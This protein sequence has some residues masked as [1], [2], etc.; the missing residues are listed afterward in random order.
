MLQTVK[1]EAK[2]LQMPMPNP[3]RIKKVQKSMAM[4]KVVIGER[5]RAVHRLAEIGYQSEEQGETTLEVDTKKLD[6]SS[7]GTEVMTSK[8]DP[9]GDCNEEKT[10]KV[11]E[12]KT[13]MT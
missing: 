3:E 4:I 10:D 13:L 9:L 6:S 1:A 7:Q 8:K 2:R 11:Y 12:S 5:E